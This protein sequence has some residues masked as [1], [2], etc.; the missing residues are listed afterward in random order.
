MSG[1]GGVDIIAVAATG[2]RFVVQCKRWAK[3][4][5]SPEIRD[6]LGA[7]HAYPGHR[8]VL[9]TTAGFTGPARQATAG[10]ELILIDRT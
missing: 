6:L 5:G 8:G 3:S 10:T 4:V 1:D 7:L 2:E 9:V